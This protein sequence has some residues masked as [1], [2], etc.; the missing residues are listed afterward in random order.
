MFW[1]VLRSGRDLML[2]QTADLNDEDSVVLDD[3]GD[4]S[5]DSADSQNSSANSDSQDSQNSDK[6]DADRSSSED[7]TEEDDLEEGEGSMDEITQQN[8]KDK[9][10]DPALVPVHVLYAPPPPPDDFTYKLK[11]FLGFLQIVSSVVSGLEVQAPNTYKQMILLFDIFNFDVLLSN[12]TSA[13]CVFNSSFY[14]SKFLFIVLI[15][16]VLLVIVSLF[17]LLPR[18]FEICCFKHSTIQ[19]RQRSRSSGSYSCMS[20]S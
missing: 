15:P 17:F 3:D 2:Q 11:I 6:S 19:E 10:N 18:Y 16:V 9:E 4:K 8:M 1:I 13:Q 12:V 7:S 5:E 14:Y 20:Y